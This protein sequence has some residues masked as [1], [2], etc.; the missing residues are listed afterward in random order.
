MRNLIGRTLG[1]SRLVEKIH[2]GGMGEVCLAKGAVLDW[3]IFFKQ[4]T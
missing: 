4:R 2:E 1:H 3:R